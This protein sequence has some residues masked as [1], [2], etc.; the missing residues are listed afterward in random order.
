MKLD[1]KYLKICGAYPNNET[2]I[3]LDLKKT[4]A[5]LINRDTL[6]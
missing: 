5:N 4:I 6:I 3:F 2:L 1:L